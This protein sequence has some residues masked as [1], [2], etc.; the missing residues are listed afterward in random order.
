VTSGPDE[1]LDAVA[2]LLTAKSTVLLVTPGSASRR[3]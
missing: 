3:W 1:P 2:D